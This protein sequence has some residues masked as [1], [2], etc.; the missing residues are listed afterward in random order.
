MKTG[1]VLEG[2]A[3]RTIFSTGVCDALLTRDLL[4]DYVIGVSAGIAYG[5]SY[6]SK[7]S[8]RN[9]D[10]MVN[11]INDKRYMGFGNLLRRD[12]RAYFG[13]DFVFGTIPNEL[14][15]FDYDTF[16]AYPG[17]VEAVVTNLDTGKAEYFPVE[18][19]DDRFKLLQATCALPF[20]FPVFDIQGKPCMDGGA[21]DAIPYERALERGCERVI[22]VL[23]RERSYSKGPSHAQQRV[24]ARHFRR[25]PQ[26]VETMARRAEAYNQ[27]RR[28][29]FAMEGSGKVLILE[30]EST[31]GFSRTERDV[32]KIRALWQSGYSVGHRALNDVRAFWTEE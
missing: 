18:R 25:Y 28:D 11:Y 19:R 30:P 8:R 23:T 14:I 31:A 27:S 10:I 17:E 1:I 7:Q 21:A 24:L 20:L 13:L 6:V 4:P 9:L 32:E 16:A 22:V 3:V 5:V 29:L 15:P 2:G 26:F 12:N